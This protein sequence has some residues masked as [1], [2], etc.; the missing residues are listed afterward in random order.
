[1]AMK[2]KTKK[3]GTGRKK[4]DEMKLIEDPAKRQVAFSKRRPTLFGMAGD[5]SALCGVHVAVVVFSRSARGNAYAFGSPSVDA[6]LRRYHQDGGHD[7]DDDATA[8]AVHGDDDAGALAALRRELDDTRTRVEAEKKRM[9][10]V[11]ANVERAMAARSTALWW[12][13]DVEA[14]GAAELPEFETALWRLRD[15]LLRRVDALQLPLAAAPPACMN[16]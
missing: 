10:A 8:L 9:K 7:E 14:L 1:M 12:Q 3:G 4:R 5:L 2:M 15:T 6:V 16:M 11:E 13:A